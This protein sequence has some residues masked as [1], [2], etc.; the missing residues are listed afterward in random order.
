MLAGCS[1]TQSPQQART[2][3][4]GV[5][6]FESIIQESLGDDLALPHQSQ[7]HVPPETEQQRSGVISHAFESSTPEMI[8]CCDNEIAFHV[9]KSVKQKIWRHEFVNLAVLLKGGVE[10]ADIYG[11]NLL[12]INE[13]GQLETKP[14]S[15]TDKIGSVNKWTDA[16]LIFASV[17]LVEYPLKTQEI[18]KYMSV[19]REAATR[20]PW[21][22]CRAYDEQFR[23]RQALHVQSWALINADLWL[24]C[25]SRVG[26]LPLQNQ[27]VSPQSKVT[28]Q[29]PAC[30]HF[31][32]GTCRWLVCR[33]WHV[34]SICYSSTHGRWACS[35]N[36]GSNSS[37]NS[38][39][40]PQTARGSFCGARNNRSFRRGA[41]RFPQRGYYN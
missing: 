1:G 37:Q 34:C 14:K 41:R 21:F 22:Q 18:F 25:F 32:K 13:L 26:P 31:N 27:S 15:V 9:P 35:G 33:Y 29:S 40:Q 7:S 20:S 17:Y 4:S 5:I 11:S 38:Y 19:I 2:G 28:S 8:K 24:R 3:R 16:F 30:L 36:Q 6:D 10:L 39:V 23:L 12:S